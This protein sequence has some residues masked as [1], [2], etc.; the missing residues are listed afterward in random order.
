MHRADLPGAAAGRQNGVSSTTPVPAR[1]VMTA[2]PARAVPCA[3]S[4]AAQPVDLSDPATRPTDPHD[5]HVQEFLLAQGSPSGS[6]IQSRLFEK[7]LLLNILHGGGQIFASQDDPHAKLISY[8]IS[9]PHPPART[10]SAPRPTAC[11]HPADRDGHVQHAMSG[12]R[13]DCPGAARAGARA[14][15]RSSLC[16]RCAPASP[17]PPT[18]RTARDA[19]APA[20]ATA[21]A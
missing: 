11:S 21:T 7:P 4:S 18:P 17:P 16:G 9:T 15:L 14:G 6:P 5:R 8:W 13:R 19:T 10:N 2:T 1:A 20:V 3:S 12:S